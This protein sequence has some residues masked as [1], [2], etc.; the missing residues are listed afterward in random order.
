MYAVIPPN[1]ESSAAMIAI[2]KNGTPAGVKS[3]GIQNPTNIPIII[4]KIANIIIRHL[5]NPQV[6]RI[7]F[8]TLR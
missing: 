1:T 4:A 7:A 5:L 8:E 3:C 2:A 6:A